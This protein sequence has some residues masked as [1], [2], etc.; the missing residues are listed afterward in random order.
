MTEAAFTGTLVAANRKIIGATVKNPDG[1]TLGTVDDL[2]VDPTSG[3]VYYAVMSFG[4]ILGLG[5]QYYPVPWELVASEPS[6]EAFVVNMDKAR[7]ESAP[8]YGLQFEWTR[9]YAAE[10]DTYYGIDR[11]PP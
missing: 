1:E 7:L 6:Q 8:N 3:R 4:G 11:P 2:M 9:R 10:V 5:K